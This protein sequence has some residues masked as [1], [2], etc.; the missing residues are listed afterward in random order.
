MSEVTAAERDL[1]PNYGLYSF[2]AHILGPVLAL[3]GGYSVYNEEYLSSLHGRG[4]TVAA[5]HTT[6]MEI[7]IIGRTVF[8]AT[9]GRPLLYMTKPE[10]TDMPV[11]GPFLKYLGAER[12]LR[13]TGR[14]LEG[15]AKEH[16][17]RFVRAGGLV[18]GFPEGT[19]SKTIDVT[20][21]KKG[22]AHISLENESP[23]ATLGVAANIGNNSL[24]R[25]PMVIVAGEIVEPH[26]SRDE[27]LALSRDDRSMHAGIMIRKAADI[28]V[29]CNVVAQG[30][31]KEELAARAEL[32]AEWRIPGVI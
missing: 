28:I 26:I 29:E 11:V 32:A 19:R 22:L 2:G 18:L 7:P 13:N 27:Y 16:I 4:A 1:M 5:K 9:G 10:I 31:L 25:Q 20:K 6:G 3:T 17:D 24:T 30:H 14:G 12:T 15:E 8:M 23:M 21:F